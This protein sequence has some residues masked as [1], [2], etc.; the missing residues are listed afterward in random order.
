MSKNYIFPIVVVLLVVG[1]Y[2]VTNNKQPAKQD[3]PSI[4]QNSNQNKDQTTS[5]KFSGE[6]GEKI[7]L[8]NG[9]VK[10]KAELLNDGLAHYYNVKMPSGKIIYFFVVKDK[11]GIY[12]AAANACKICFDA[13]KGFRQEGNY[14]V[15]NTCGNKYPMEKIATEKGGCNPGPIDPNLKSENGEIIINQANLEEALELF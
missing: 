5:L 7:E 12:R 3:K 10:I 11:N 9:Q 4:I 6:Q 15:C 1:A 14:M 8:V 13:R 2:L